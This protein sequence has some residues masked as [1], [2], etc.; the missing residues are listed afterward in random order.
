M[1]DNAPAAS[2]AAAKA[3]YVCNATA[4]PIDT[5]LVGT[6]VV[7]ENLGP[8]VASPSGAACSMPGATFTYPPSPFDLTVNFS[9]GRVVCRTIDSDPDTMLVLIVA[10]LNGFLVST[11]EGTARELLFT[12]GA[13]TTLMLLPTDRSEP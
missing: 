12:S 1:T 6:S 13:A 8:M 10:L 11:A 7:G 5:V 9:N 4:V 2:S 3:G